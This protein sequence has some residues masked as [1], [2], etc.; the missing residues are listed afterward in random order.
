ME[1]LVGGKGTEVE[2]CPFS[3]ASILFYSDYLDHQ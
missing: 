3:V 1:Q 2:W